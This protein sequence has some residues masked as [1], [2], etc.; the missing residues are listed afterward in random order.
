[1]KTLAE[2]HLHGIIHRLKEW[3]KDTESSVPVKLLADAAKELEKMSAE[4]AKNKLNEN[5]T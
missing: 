2:I 1:M 3:A 4:I 5:K